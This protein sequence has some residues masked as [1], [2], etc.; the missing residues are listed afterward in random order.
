LLAFG[1]RL[2]QIK[3]TL[4]QTIQALKDTA[5]FVDNHFII[6]ASEKQLN[7][8]QQQ[9][10]HRD[11][12]LEAALQEDEQIQNHFPLVGLSQV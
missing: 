7:L 6:K 3:V 5:D 11:Q 4:K 10:G 12:Q 1:D 8:I 2:T 9:I